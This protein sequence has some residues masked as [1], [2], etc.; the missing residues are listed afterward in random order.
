MNHTTIVSVEWLSQ[1][2]DAPNLIVLDASLKKNQAKLD[3]IYS[4]VQIKGARFVDLKNIFSD[5]YSTVPNT[6]LPAD[7][8][9]LECQKLGINKEHKIVVYDN[10]GI[11]S[12]PRIWWMFQLMGHKNTAVLD[13]GLPAWILAKGPTEPISKEIN[14][15]KIGTFKANYQSHWLVNKSEVT[16][17]IDH[18]KAFVIDARSEER[19]LGT[20]LESRKNLRSGHIPKALNLPFKY[21]LNQGFLKKKE[22]LLDLIIALKLEKRALIFS[23]GSGVTACIVLLALETIIDNPKA[24]YDGSWSEWGSIEE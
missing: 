2:I 4:N 15:F 24:L 16:A 20:V 22:A 17:N 3:A 5:Q 19:F 1:H 6:M 11:Y 13:G 9:S 18:S 23:C 12:S 8:F 14:T 10:L 7:L 21:V